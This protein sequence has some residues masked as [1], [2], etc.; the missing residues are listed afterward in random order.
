[1]QEISGTRL[2]ADINLGAQAL[3]LIGLWVG[4][5]F[6]RTMQATKHKNTQTTIVLIQPI[7]ILFSMVVS[8]YNYVILGGTVPR[9]R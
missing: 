7:F 2:S 8:Y 1:M 3:M 5:Y 6:A 9:E 4:V